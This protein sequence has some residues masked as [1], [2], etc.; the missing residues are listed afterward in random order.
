MSPLHRQCE[1]PEL[2]RLKK[3]GKNTH[4]FFLARGSAQQSERARNGTGAHTLV[5]PG[6]P[7]ICSL[8]S[9]GV[10]DPVLRLHP[11]PTPTISGFGPAA[12]E[13]DPPLGE[14]K[15]EVCQVR[16][17]IKGRASSS[18][19]RLP[20]LP[21]RL[22]HPSQLLRAAGRIVGPMP[23]DTGPRLRWDINDPEMPQVKG[24]GARGAERV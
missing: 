14:R 21:L 4:T 13:G 24:R 5:R 12:A 22:G 3:K 2:G 15:A 16:D 11:F 10:E 6:T 9:L 20:L 18:P 17:F 8:F 1:T 7:T 19:L 23:L